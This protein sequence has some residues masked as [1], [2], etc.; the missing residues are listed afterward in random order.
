MGKFYVG[1]R[2]LVTSSTFNPMPWTE[3]MI[4]KICELKERGDRWA[5]FTPDKSDYWFF[6]ESDLQPITETPETMTINGVEYVRKPDPD[7]EWKFGDVA[8]HKKYGVGIITRNIDD[9]GDVEFTCNNGG[10]NQYVLPRTLTFIR[11]TDFSV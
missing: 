2:V 3:E 8:V 6:N 10:D 11:R 4:G 5:V 1:Q 9:D 7:H